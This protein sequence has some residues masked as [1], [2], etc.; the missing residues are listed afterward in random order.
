M[1]KEFF[2]TFVYMIWIYSSYLPL[3]SLK[4]SI[5]NISKYS[6]MCN[7]FSL[8]HDIAHIEI[9]HLYNP[10][11]IPNNNVTIIFTLCEQISSIHVSRFGRHF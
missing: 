5:S 7:L 6:K 3:N 8:F 9:F 11:K 2:H 4:Y 10:D 1:H